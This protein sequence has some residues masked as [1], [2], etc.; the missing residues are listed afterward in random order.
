[1]KW[2]RLKTST[3][4]I[5]DG[6]KIE[7][8]YSETVLKSVTLTDASG[9]VARVV[10]DSYSLYLEVPAPPATEKKWELSGT[11]KGLAVRELFA[12][13]HEAKYRRDELS[14]ELSIAE[15][16]VPVEE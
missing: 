11:F 1:M 3:A 12:Y 5:L 2:T 15:V 10:I 4:N 13:E 8:D 9:H 6:I 14:D 7:S 16:D